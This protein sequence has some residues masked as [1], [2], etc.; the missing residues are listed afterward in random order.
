MLY[1]PLVLPCGATGCF[2]LGRRLFFSLR[3]FIFQCPCAIQRSPVS[4]AAVVA[5]MGDAFYPS[6]LSFH[7]FLC[8]RS[9]MSYAWFCYCLL[10]PICK[11]YAL[12][13]LIAQCWTGGSASSRISNTRHSMLLCRGPPTDNTSQCGHGTIVTRLQ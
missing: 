6:L 4:Y 8:L 10:S 9:P 5:A 12:R 3:L 1:R 11:S 2:W 7:Y 13:Q